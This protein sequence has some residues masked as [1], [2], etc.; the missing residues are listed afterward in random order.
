MSS[1]VRLFISSCPEMWRAELA[2]EYSIYKHAEHDVEVYFLR[3]GDEG[4]QSNL[5]FSLTSLA[6]QAERE[7]LWNIG[8]QSQR[9][10]NKEGWSMPYQCFRFAIPELCGY[11]GRAIH[12]TADF[13][14]LA[15]LKSLFEMD[16]QAPM[17][18]P[19]CRTDF[20]I[21]DCE[22]FAD[23]EWWPSI[24]Q[25]KPS[26]WHI[27]K[28]YKKWLLEH[29]YLKASDHQFE[30]WDGNNYIPNVTK[31]IHFSNM[32]TQPW[33]P[34]PQY[35]SY[36]PH[37]N[38]VVTYLFWE[39][40]AEALER[41]LIGEFKPQTRIDIRQYAELGYTP[42]NR[43][44]LEKVLTAIDSIGNDLIIES[45]NSIKQIHDILG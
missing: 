20:M 44:E 30:S 10:F 2:L 43:F 6:A 1:P 9:Y 38:P 34:F 24:S 28:H 27:E 15:D 11:Q 42:D 31:T 33:K 17:M 25:M 35:V 3:S 18:G 39:H 23:L 29:Q 32:H 4:W 37:P 12:M 19:G 40:Y 26:G 8:H 45:R 36:L 22:R 5:D 13:L 16:M 41:L 7:D 14:V 21:I